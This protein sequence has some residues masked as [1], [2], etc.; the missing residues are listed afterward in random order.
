MSNQNNGIRREELEDNSR[1]SSVHLTAK[2]VS[3]VPD[4]YTE[5]F[6]KPCRNATAKFILCQESRSTARMGYCPK[7]QKA[8]QGSEGKIICR[9][10]ASLSIKCSKTATFSGFCKPC[11]S[12]E[13]EEN[14]SP[15]FCKNKDNPWVVCSGYVSKYPMQY[16]NVCSEKMRLTGVNKLA[17]IKTLC[18]NSCAIVR[19]CK[20]IKAH[21]IDGYCTYCTDEL[22]DGVKAKVRG[23]CKGEYCNMQPEKGCGGFCSG[24]F[25]MTRNVKYQLAE[26][27]EVLATEYRNMLNTLPEEQVIEGNDPALQVYLPKKHFNLSEYSDAPE[28]IPWHHCRV[29]LKTIT[30]PVNPA[31]SNDE[32]FQD[33]LEKHAEEIH[34]LCWQEFR[35]R[36]LETEMS[37]FPNPVRSQVH[38]FQLAKFRS[39]IND[40]AFELNGCACCG[41]ECVYQEMVDA[42][43]PSRSSGRLPDWLR[44]YGWVQKDWDHRRDKWVE[45]LNEA[46]GVE[47]YLERHFYIQERM[48]TTTTIA[49]ADPALQERYKQR[50]EEYIKNMRKDLISDSPETIDGYQRWLFL[51]QTTSICQDEEGGM[52]LKAVLCTNCSKT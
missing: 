27:E 5:Y 1:G 49:F 24:C 48:E 29:C 13:K 26:V 3:N 35:K 23:C 14:K 17:P 15:N 44:K 19:P 51:K 11:L 25:K 36:V 20:K 7:C 6:K 52:Q 12:K 18:R 9:N 50:V 40:K 4:P 16:C 31:K 10:V 2:D 39:E 33:A 32:N 47:H 43:F 37:L 30:L 46:F 28:H 8:R 41:R 22:N 45:Q 38:R 42:I 21:G 34:G